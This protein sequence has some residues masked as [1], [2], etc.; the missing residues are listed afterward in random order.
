MR[1]LGFDSEN[2]L[3]VN[4]GTERFLRRREEGGPGGPRAPVRRAAPPRAAGWGWG[5]S[6]SWGCFLDWPAGP[7]RSTEVPPKQFL[8]LGKMWLR[9]ISAP[10]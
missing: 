8:H 3:S 7:A 6:G 1:S 2:A 5:L 4:I 10:G 9:V